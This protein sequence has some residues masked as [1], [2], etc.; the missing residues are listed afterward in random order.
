M[1]E[2]HSADLYRY[3]QCIIVVYFYAT[4]VQLMNMKYIIK[5]QKLC[6]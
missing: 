2:A 3:Q 1:Y 6:K 4:Q 5:S